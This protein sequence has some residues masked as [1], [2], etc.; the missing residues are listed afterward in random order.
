MGSEGCGTGNGPVEERQ[1]LRKG[2][3]V[4]NGATFL[5]NVNNDGRRERMARGDFG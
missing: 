1:G 2:Y 3:A 4:T 5:D